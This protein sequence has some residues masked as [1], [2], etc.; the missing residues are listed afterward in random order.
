MTF[1]IRVG[2]S[3]SPGW[4]EWAAFSINGLNQGLY[5]FD[6]DLPKLGIQMEMLETR[7]EDAASVTKKE[8]A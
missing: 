8:S 7:K 4:R 6:I 1:Q 3:V 2:Q 5:R